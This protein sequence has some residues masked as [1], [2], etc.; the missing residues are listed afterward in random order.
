M[1]IRLRRLSADM[2]QN[3]NVRSCIFIMIAMVILAAC[4][5]IDCP[6]NNTVYANYVLTGKV[7]KLPDTLTIAIARQNAPDSVLINKQVDAKTFSLPMSYGQDVD[8]LHFQTGRIMDTVWVEKTNRPHFESVDC[9]LNYF[10]TITGVRYTRHAID[11]IVIN[12]KEVTYDA[13]QQ[14]FHIYYKEYRL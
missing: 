1:I 9:G 11:S 5:S 7:S 10:H 14:H 12:Q 4:S 3:H 2:K 8:R 6:L 13:S